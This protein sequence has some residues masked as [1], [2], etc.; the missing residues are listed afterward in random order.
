VVKETMV[1]ALRG[2]LRL[3]GMGV[4]LVRVD[5]HEVLTLRK[6]GRESVFIPPHSVELNL[7][8]VLTA[9]SGKRWAYLHP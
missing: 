5:E 6:R 9:I 1:K 4:F 7:D 8:L 3:V 2:L